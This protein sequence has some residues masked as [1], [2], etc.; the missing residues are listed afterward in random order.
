MPIPKTQFMKF[1]KNIIYA[2]RHI[3]PS[4][5]VL[6][7][8]EFLLLFPATTGIRS[9]GSSDHLVKWPEDFVGFISDKY[10]I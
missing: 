9:L 6:P 7:P 2:H 5:T 10:I 4:D 1:S 3:C 8:S